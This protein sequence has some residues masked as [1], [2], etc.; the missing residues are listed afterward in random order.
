[1]LC[2]LKLDRAQ[3]AEER[4][5]AALVADSANSKAAYRRGLARLRLGDAQGAEQDLHK[6]VRLEP[7][8]L[9]VR[10]R[11]EEARQLAEAAPLAESEVSAAV[12]ATAAL[13]KGEGLYREK[14]DLNEGRLADSYKE[15]KEWVRSI[16][17]WTE[18]TNIS[19]AD[20]EGDKNCV[21]VYMSLLGDGGG[22]DEDAF[23]QTESEYEEEYFGEYASSGEETTDD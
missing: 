20:E 7:Q 11:Y 17:N 21:S 3:E 23:D 16:S 19:F 18:I 6:A 1:A 10:Q 13:G 12:G 9:E 8:N 15:Q 5:S 22:E 4:A 14:L 2:L